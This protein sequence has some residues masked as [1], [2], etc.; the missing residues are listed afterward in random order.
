MPRSGP[1]RRSGF[2]A[3]P[4]PTPPA[5]C[6]K[7]GWR[8]PDCASAACSVSRPGPPSPARSRPALG[9]ARLPP[10][11][12]FDLLL[13]AFAETA[14][15]P[16]WMAGGGPLRDD[17]AR[18][19][20]RLGLGGRVRFLGWREDVPALRRTADFLVCPSRHEPL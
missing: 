18:Q 13:D 16:L 10:N 19:A 14:A 12:G 1:A 15:I 6:K 11:R 5:L 2:W 8:S 17:L 3:R 7:T 9:F 4:I 20:E